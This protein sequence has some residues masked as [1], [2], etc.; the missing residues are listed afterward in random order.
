MILAIDTTHDQG[1]I[2]LVEAGQVLEEVSLDGEDGFSSLLFI[3]I[4]D[5]LARHNITLGA[6]DAFAAASGPGTFTGIRIGLT[7]AKGFGESMGK[8]VFGI[9][10]LEALATYAPGAIPFYDAR[11]GDVYTMLADGIER[12]LPFDQLPSL[13][14]GN[15]HWVTFDP[16]LYPSLTATAAPRAIAAAI[17]KLAEARYLDGQ[18][19]DAAALD[20][21]YVRRSDAELNLRVT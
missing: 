21:N 19:P 12:V 10:N 17:A 4:Q 18:R 16:T 13:T 3:A 7:V 2:A 6:I 20:A 14:A 11:R 9:G 1:S 5:L 8:P 15:S